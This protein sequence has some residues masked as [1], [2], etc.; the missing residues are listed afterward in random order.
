MVRR[1]AAFDAIYTNAQKER[2]P[3]D[4]PPVLQLDIFGDPS[5][6][7]N[8]YLFCY[9]TL[10][11]AERDEPAANP[12]TSISRNEQLLFGQL[13]SS[14]HR[15][16]DLDHSERVFFVFGDLAVKITCRF[17]LKFSLWEYSLYL[18]RLP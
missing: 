5:P 1:R 6:L 18:L 13:S 3:L 4:P 2:K 7:S 9:C 10:W 17:R 11:H 8:P 16:K 14:V 12:A 15:A